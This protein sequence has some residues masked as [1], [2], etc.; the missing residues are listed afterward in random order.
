VSELGPVVAIHQPNF[1]PWL[2]Y[3]DKL[4][5]AD[6]FIFLDDAQLPRRGGSWVNRVKLAVGGEPHWL[7]APIIRPSGTQR[8]ADVQIDDGRR[9]RDK[10]LRTVRQSYGACPHF[11]ETFPVVEDILRCSTSS[12]VELNETAIRRLSS[13]VEGGQGTRLVRSSELGV[14]AGGTE[15][16][17]ELTKRVGGRIY[18]SGDG[19]AGYQ[20]PSHFEDEGVTLRYQRFDHPRYPQRT[21]GFTPGLSVVDALM[22]VGSEGVSQR[23]TSPPA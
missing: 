13:V 5:K 18:L 20:E 7:T 12:L 8:I 9:W 11:D 14:D 1:L 3:F 6:V 17:I 15:R 10:A 22:N 21:P 19:S 2:G 16:L 23:L 4:R